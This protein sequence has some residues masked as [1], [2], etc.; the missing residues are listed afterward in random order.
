MNG[1]VVLTG[2]YE[3]GMERDKSSLLCKLLYLASS[4]TLV[5]TSRQ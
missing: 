2:N 1:S 3:E 5:V 4:T